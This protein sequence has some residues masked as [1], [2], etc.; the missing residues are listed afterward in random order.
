MAHGVLHLL[1][2]NDKKEAEKTLMRTKENEMMQLFHV[3]Q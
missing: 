3:E 1:D 2:Y